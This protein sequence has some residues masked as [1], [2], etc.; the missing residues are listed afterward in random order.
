VQLRRR[1]PFSRD[2]ELVGE[3]GVSLAQVRLQALREAGEIEA[4]DGRRW[5]VRRDPG[6][7]PWRVADEG[8]ATLVTATKDGLRERFEIEW[9]T[10]GLRL[11]RRSS[12]GQRRLEVLDGASGARV[13]EIRQRGWTGSTHE[14]DLPIAPDEVVG[15]VAW[16]VAMLVQRDAAAASQS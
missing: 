9:P 4:A 11:E 3:D 7:G 13:G 15:T 1:G 14:L 5:T 12:L 8:G 6:F 10:G 2:H 16:L